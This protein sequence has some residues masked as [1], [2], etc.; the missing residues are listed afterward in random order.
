MEKQWFS[1]SFRR[2]LVDMHIADWS[3]EF[4]SRFDPHQYFDCLQKGKIQSTMIYLQSHTGLCNWNSQ[5]GRTH[6]AFAKENKMKILID[7]CHQN[8]M[9]VI[10]YYSLIYNNC[11]YEEHP[12]WRM[13]DVHGNPS[14]RDSHHNFMGGGRYGLVC[15][16]QN[17]YREFLLQQFRELCGTYDFEGIFLDMT[18]WPFPCYCD[19][20]RRLYREEAGKELPATADWQ[21][22]EWKQYQNHRQKWIGEFAQFC[23][24]QVKELRSEV[25]VE[26]QFSTICHD[27]SFGI[28]EK[29]NEANDYIGGDLYGGHLQE[30]YICKIYREATRNQPFEYMTSRCDPGLLVHTTTKTKEQLRLHNQ[31]TLSHHGAMLFIDAIDPAGT[32]NPAVYD[33]IGEVFAETQP[34]EPY[35]NGD[36]ISEAALIM[37]YDS[38]YDVHQP[39]ASPD[40]AGRSHPQLDAQIGMARVLKE[41][42]MLFTVLP[43]NRLEKL[44]GKKI[45]FLTNATSLRE[46]E[47]DILCRYVEQGG[48]L[49]LSGTTDPHLAKRLL[50]LNFLG[51]TRE[52]QTYLSPTEAGTDVFGEEYSAQYPLAFPGKQMLM[53][54]PDAHPVLA[55]ITLPYTDPADTQ[56]F[57]SIHSN[58]PGIPTQFPAVVFG[59]WGKG[60]IIWTSAAVETMSASATAKVVSRIIQKL[61]HPR[62]L[63]TNAPSCV[64]MLLFDDSENHRYLLHAVNVQEQREILP[65][66][67]FSI[68]LR[69]PKTCRSAYSL[70]DKEPLDCYNKSDT[71]TIPVSKLE[72]ALHIMLPYVEP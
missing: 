46:S 15:P 54:N 10:A 5:S 38:K 57:A 24:N 72:I 67:D 2:N 53:E 3:D 36:M 9:D 69:L 21:N 33:R 47:M 22:P 70:P 25:S 52:T 43:S 8:H 49:Y 63:H 26:H 28:D 68:Q 31:L 6:K 59:H 1:R 71:L 66:Y 30:S 44:E 62:I 60:A 19:A 18:F 37:S 32:L 4:L 29:V 41:M 42:S 20:C 13:L 48:N 14:R 45:A 40:H 58:P 7:L 23:T 35:L 11:A 50:G 16:N 27:W 39:P 51:Y 12:E 64:E 55:T 34:M 56:R 65:I 17:G 61:V